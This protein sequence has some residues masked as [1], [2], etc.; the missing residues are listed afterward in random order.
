A[1]PTIK[2]PLELEWR[3]EKSQLE[4]RVEHA[5]KLQP[6]HQ[7]WEIEATTQVQVKALF[8]TIHFVDLKLPAPRPRG[9]ALIGTATPG[10][11]FPGGLPWAGVWKTFG[12]PWTY[13]PGDE[14]TVLDEQGAALKLLP[15]DAGK[16][17]VMLERPAG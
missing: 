5:L 10:L 16:T 8:A 11:A 6:G 9:V 17:R 14:Y 1:A 13:A 15:Q 7:S 4:T 2:A 3:F 12:L